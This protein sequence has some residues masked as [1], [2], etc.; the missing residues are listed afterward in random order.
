MPSAA[1]VVAQNGVV[2]QD[3]AVEVKYID[4]PATLRRW[5]INLLAAPCQAI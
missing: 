1:V 2:L 4:L 3:H 5:W